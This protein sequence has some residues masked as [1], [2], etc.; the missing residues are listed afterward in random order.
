MGDIPLMPGSHFKVIDNFLNKKDFKKIQERLL[1]KDFPWY[2]T[3]NITFVD[4]KQINIILHICFI[5]MIDL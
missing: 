1:A 5:I 3:P 2:Y 4:E